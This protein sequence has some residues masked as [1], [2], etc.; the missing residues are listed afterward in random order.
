MY[1][2]IIMILENHN[3]DDKKMFFK[4][5]KRLLMNHVPLCRFIQKKKKRKLF[6]LFHILTT[7]RIKYGTYDNIKF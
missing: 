6:K 3:F 4:C 5:P 1:I 2:S 7:N